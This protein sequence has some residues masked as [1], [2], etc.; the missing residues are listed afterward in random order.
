MSEQAALLS[1]RQLW[2]WLLWKSFCRMKGSVTL[3][4][5][6]LGEC[7]AQGPL[8]D[9]LEVVGESQCSRHLQRVTTQRRSCQ[10]I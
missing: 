2:K 1:C 3:P 7:R 5:G 9:E 8:W 4:A 6:R 10:D